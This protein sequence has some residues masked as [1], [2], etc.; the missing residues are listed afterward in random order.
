ME[1]VDQMHYE[2]CV[3]NPFVSEKEKK[4]GKSTENSETCFAE[5]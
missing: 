2:H 1:L 3:E 5:K 4:F